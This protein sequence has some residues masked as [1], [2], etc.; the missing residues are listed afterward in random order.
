MK[1]KFKLSFAFLAF[2][3]CSTASAEMAFP[4][5]AIPQLNAESYILIDAKSGEIL[6]Q[7]N[8][9]QQRDPASLTKMMTSYVIGQALQSGRIKNDDMVVVSKD[10]WAT[11]NPEI[12]RASCRE[13]V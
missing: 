4:I 12:G 10:A 8:A 7:Y 3:I 1:K 6:A 13:R 9:E 11:G 5:P 2:A